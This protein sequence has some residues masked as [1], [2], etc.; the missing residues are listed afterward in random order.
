[1]LELV[2]SHSSDINA[3]NAAG[4]TPLQLAVQG[5]NL[6]TAQFLI[7]KGADDTVRDVQ[8]RTMRERIDQVLRSEWWKAR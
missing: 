6:V 3:G 2:V 4:L 8:G 7:A 5:N 1:M